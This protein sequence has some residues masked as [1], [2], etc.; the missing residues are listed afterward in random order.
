MMDDRDINAAFGNIQSADYI[1]IIGDLAAG[2]L[3][4]DEEEFI[5]VRQSDIVAIVK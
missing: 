4:L 5:I 3:Q 1:D 2:V